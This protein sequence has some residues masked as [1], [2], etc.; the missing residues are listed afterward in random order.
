MRNI[1]AILFVLAAAAGTARGQDEPSAPRS[2]APTASPFDSV[3]AAQFIGSHSFSLDNFFEYIPGLYVTRLGPIGLPASASR[4]GIGRGRAVVY[5]GGMPMNDPQDGT[6][7]LQLVPT[8]AIGRMIFGAGARDAIGTGIEGSLKI[9]DPWTGRERPL[10][11]LDI[12]Q[13]EVPKHRNNRVLFAT[14]PGRVTGQFGYDEFWGSGYSFDARDLISGQDY[15]HSA[16]RVQSGGL[17]GKLGGDDYRV[18]FRD[19]ESSYQGDARSFASKYWRSGYHAMFESSVERANVAVFQRSYQVIAPDS[20]TDNIT[21]AFRLDM[22]VYGRSG[23]SMS[24][25]VSLDDIIAN[26]TVGGASSHERLQT[27]AVRLTGRAE[28]GHTALLFAAGAAQQF[29]Y[30]TA[31]EGYLSVVSRLGGRHFA[32]AYARRSFRLPNL[33]ELFLPAHVEGGASYSGN[34]DLDAETALEAGASI[35]SNGRRLDHELRALALRVT[36]ILPTATAPS[37]YAPQNLD[38]QVVGIVEDRFTTGGKLADFDLVTTGGVEVAFGDREGFFSGVPGAR[39]SISGS[40]GHDLFQGTS[41]LVL[42]GQYVFSG[43]RKS[44]GEILPSWGVLNIKLDARLVDFRAY[45]MLL[46]VFDEQYMTAYPF[47]MTPRMIVYGAS[48]AFN[49]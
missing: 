26:Q 30:A 7:P 34:R 19:F 6:A 48:W 45:L 38:R 41:G 21:T 39:F 27:A 23:G 13:A 3:S 10:T 12:S 25:H 31:W 42:T 9:E 16:I 40:A 17:R 1:A 8:S 14:A 37:T 44:A 15:G 47:L 4:Y 29:G 20:L 2:P 32:S 11:V 35:V 18:S 24:A 28:R 22:P 5:I 46:N 33:G 43:E 36:P 49:S